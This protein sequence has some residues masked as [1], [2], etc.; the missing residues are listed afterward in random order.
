[1]LKTILFLILFVTFNQECASGNILK[2]I[3]LEQA[4][5]L[6]CNLFILESKC[7]ELKNLDNVNV[8]KVIDLE[9]VKA[10]DFWYKITEEKKYYYEGVVQFNDES[11]EYRINNDMI[12]VQTFRHVDFIDLMLR[13]GIFYLGN[14]RSLIQDEQGS[15]VY[16]ASL[17][18]PPQRLT[19]FQNFK[20]LQNVT[21]DGDYI[22]LNAESP[23]GKPHVVY[24]P[25]TNTKHI[26]RNFYPSLQDY[27]YEKY[28]W[29]NPGFEF[30]ND[31]DIKINQAGDLILDKLTFSCWISAFHKKKFDKVFIDHNTDEKESIYLKCS[32]AVNDYYIFNVKEKKFY[33]IQNTPEYNE[34]DINKWFYFVDKPCLIQ[35]QQSLIGY[36][37][38]A[39][40]VSLKN[41][42]MYCK[43]YFRSSKK[44]A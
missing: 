38:G 27:Y 34:Y 19:L 5:L 36:Y 12:K 22:V 33:S 41:W 32:D 43:N 39:Y 42:F 14:N 10:F 16:D 15:V 20:K 18:Q 35:L 6:S 3:C 2:P 4:Y 29:K 30:K 24:N 40:L 7:S 44:T 13:N 25:L 9:R 26:K 28:P 37:F 17:E 11:I 31:N 1:M 23:D 21:I 8:D